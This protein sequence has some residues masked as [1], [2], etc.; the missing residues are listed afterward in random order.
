[1]KFTYVEK[2]Y[3]LLF[4]NNV[5]ML[6]KVNNYKISPLEAVFKTCHIQAPILEI[7]FLISVLR[8]WDFDDSET[9][10]RHPCSLR[11]YCDR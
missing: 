9:S 11:Q 6:Y 7:L 2:K 3:A 1:M 8:K 10:A 4:V 5:L